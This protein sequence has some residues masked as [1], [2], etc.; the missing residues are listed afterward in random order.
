MNEQLN[1]LPATS[2]IAKAQAKRLRSALAP[3]LTIGHS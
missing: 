2:D 3:D 1:G